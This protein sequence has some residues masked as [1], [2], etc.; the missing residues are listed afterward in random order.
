M[1]C[2]IECSTGSVDILLR[3]EV[4]LGVMDIAEG[5]ISAKSGLV[6]ALWD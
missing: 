5:A 2:S 1:N 4:R 3:K 6:V